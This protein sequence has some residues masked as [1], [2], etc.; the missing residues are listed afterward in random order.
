MNEE[1]E[2]LKVQVSEL[3]RELQAIRAELR[4]ELPAAQSSEEDKAMLGQ[5]LMVEF[6]MRTRGEW[7][8]GDE[9]VMLEPGVFTTK[10]QQEAVEKTRSESRSN[11]FTNK[12]E[13]I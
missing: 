7:V 2:Q 3:K 6:A 8:E 13:F 1:V 5:K 4:A 9:V 12:G 10:S 11:F